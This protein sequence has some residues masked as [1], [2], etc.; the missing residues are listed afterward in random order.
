MEVRREIQAGTV[1]AN[2]EE[3]CLLIFSPAFAQLA[4]LDS[5]GNLANG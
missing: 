3:H 4:I 1:V 5:P 2:I